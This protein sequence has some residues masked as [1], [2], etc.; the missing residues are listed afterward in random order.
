MIEAEDRL[1][2]PYNVPGIYVP[3]RKSEIKDFLEY[4]FM[5][6]TDNSYRVNYDVKLISKINNTILPAEGAVKPVIQ[7]S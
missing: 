5:D 6:E 4:Y 3:A 2:L 1:V 7:N